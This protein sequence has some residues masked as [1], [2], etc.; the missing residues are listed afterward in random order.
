MNK[1]LKNNLIELD[2]DLSNSWV[3][4]SD[5]V[6]DLAADLRLKTAESKFAAEA[7]HLTEQTFRLCEH[8]VKFHA[9]VIDLIETIDTR[10]PLPE[11]DTT[12][13]PMNETTDQENIQI[14][15]EK[16][17]LSKDFKDVLKALFMWVDNPKE[18]F[19]RN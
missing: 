8:V 13:S 3:Q 19:K 15:R 14:Q 6:R 9:D 11:L 5:K 4:L 18:R 17:E 16:H 1:R 2:K 12:K 10:V 7:D